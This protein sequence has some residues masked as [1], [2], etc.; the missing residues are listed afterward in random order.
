M[1]NTYTQLYVQLVF[2]VKGRESLI[3]KAWKDNLYAYIGGI[4]LNKNSKPLAINGMSDHIH[5]FIGYNPSTSLPDLVEDI[6][7]SSNK[8]LRENIKHQYSA[9][10]KDMELSHIAVPR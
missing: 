2:S 7:T 6:K 8:Y 9:G 4:I 3:K 1:A 5:I 10:K